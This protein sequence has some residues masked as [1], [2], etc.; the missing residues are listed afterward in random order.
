M[1]KLW[2]ILKLLIVI[3]IFLVLIIIVSI[4]SSHLGLIVG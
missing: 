3:N 4:I 2:F 1:N